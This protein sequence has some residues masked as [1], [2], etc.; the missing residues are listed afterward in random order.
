MPKIIKWVMV[1]VIIIIIK[2]EGKIIEW[3]EIGK[4]IRPTTTRTERN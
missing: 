3:M 2:E 4:K 1:I